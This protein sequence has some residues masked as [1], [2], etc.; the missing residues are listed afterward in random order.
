MSRD[1]LRSGSKTDDSVHLKDRVLRFYG[2]FP[3]DRGT[4]HAPTDGDPAIASVRVPKRRLIQG[5]RG[6]ARS[7]KVWVS[8]G[9]FS[10]HSTPWPTLCTSPE[11]PA[12]PVFMAMNPVSGAAFLG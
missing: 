9:L 6:Q 3:T 8:S 2:R 5:N 10:P 11:R 12:R 4:S 7:Y 1:L